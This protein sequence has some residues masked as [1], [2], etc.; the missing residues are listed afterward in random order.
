M[1]DIGREYGSTTG[2]PRRCGWIDLPALKYAIMLNGVSQLLMMKADV[3]D[4]FEEIKVCTHY[5]LENGVVT[6][7]LPYDFAEE[8]VIPIYKSLKGWNTSL[9]G[10]AD[11][12]AMPNELKNYIAYLETAL[13]VPI[14]LVSVG[15]DRSQTLIK[16][17]IVV[18]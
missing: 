18:Q 6:E 3:L 17:E 16:Q 7:H 5:Q 12:D 8:K 1:R 15:P 13:N 11:F 14:N 4:T 10:V 9:E 2:R